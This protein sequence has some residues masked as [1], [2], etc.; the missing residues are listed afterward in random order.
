MWL[1]SWLWCMLC[2]TPLVLW[3]H[4][5]QLCARWHLKRV[6]VSLFQCNFA[7]AFNI[8]I[9]ISWQVHLLLQCNEAWLPLKPV[10]EESSQLDVAV[11]HDFLSGA[12]RHAAEGVVVVY[13]LYISHAITSNL[14]LSVTGSLM[15]IT[16]PAGCVNYACASVSVAF[17]LVHGV[18]VLTWF[19]FLLHERS[20]DMQSGTSSNSH[21]HTRSHSKQPWNAL[22]SAVP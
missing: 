13:S 1:W 3:C 10:S 12:K 9:H 11:E 18:Y 15:S 14:L 2:S 19:V 20:W 22:G 17:R 7:A 21:E 16:A 4:Q 5:E 8:V 6:A